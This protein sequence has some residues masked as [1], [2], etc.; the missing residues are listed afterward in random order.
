[1]KK[2]KYKD[3]IEN[4][5]TLASEVTINE[6]DEI[7]KSKDLYNGGYLYYLKIFNILGLSDDFID[8]MDEAALFEIMKDF[9]EE[10]N[11]ETNDFIKEFEFEGHTYVA[12]SGESFKL[13]AR[14]FANIEE[15]LTNNKE[16]WIS[17]ALAV[18]F[19]RTDLS[20]IENSLE[21]NIN[22]RTELFRDLTLDIVLPYI[23]HI[24][25]SYIKNLRLL[26]DI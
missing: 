12:Y 2:Y 1:M 13:N 11:L 16:D 18:I 19:K 7:T 24:S 14:D 25:T 8:D 3:K 5:K 6:F 4:L 10:F 17:Y 21:S 26:T 23:N 22:E 15:R 9:K 20:K